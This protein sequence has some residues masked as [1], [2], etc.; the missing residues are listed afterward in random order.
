MTILYTSTQILYQIN[1]NFNGLTMLAL[2]VDVLIII[3]FIGLLYSIGIL[4][5][6]KKR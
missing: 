3:F 2:I 6:K 1:V 5:K 4:N